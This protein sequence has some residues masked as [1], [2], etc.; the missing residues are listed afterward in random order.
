M[1]EAEVKAVYAFYADIVAE[2]EI[3]GMPEFLSTDDKIAV[4]VIK[5]ETAKDRVFGLA[6]RGFA[7]EAY[8]NSTLAKWASARCRAAYL[9]L[10]REDKKQLGEFNEKLKAAEQRAGLTP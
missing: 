2:T 4:A 7:S 9:I 5:A 10:A 6:V 8:L 1:N 3:T